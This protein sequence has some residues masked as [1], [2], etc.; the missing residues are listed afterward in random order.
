MDPIVLHHRFRVW[1]YGVGHSQLLLHARAGASDPEHVD[2]VFEG[3]RAVK[4][5]SSYQPLILQ[6][7]DETTR[8]QILTFA[9]VPARHRTRMLCLT[10]P[11]PDDEPGF[12]VCARATVVA[13]AKA[14]NEVPPA[15]SHEHSRPIHVLRQPP[16]AQ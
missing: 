1:R 14:D 4:L 8:A 12:V 9:D 2:V 6:P 13:L 11:T 3:V 16:T 5:R 15:Y 7:A 10:L